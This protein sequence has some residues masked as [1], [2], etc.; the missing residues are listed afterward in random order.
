MFRYEKIILSRQD[1]TITVEELE[2]STDIWTETV[3]VTLNGNGN[4][5]NF[6]YGSCNDTANCIG[7]LTF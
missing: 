2:L 6:D 3:E 7:T 5:L 1:W 4:S